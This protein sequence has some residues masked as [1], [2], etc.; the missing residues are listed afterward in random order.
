[1]YLVYGIAGTHGFGDNEDTL[2]GRFMEGFVNVLYNQ[3]LVL[4]EAVHTLTYHA[5]SFLDG[6]LEGTSDGHHLAYGL[7]GATQLTVYAMKLTQ[8]PTGYLTDHVVEGRLEERA[9]SLGHGVLQVEQP[10]A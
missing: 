4:Y 8:V 2:V 3:F 7:H 5:K 6:L 10:I 1:M 9:G